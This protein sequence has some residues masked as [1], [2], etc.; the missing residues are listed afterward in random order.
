MSGW[1]MDVV[2]AAGV[3]SMSRVPMGLPASLPANNAFGFYKSRHQ[4]ALS[5]VSFS[6]FPGRNDRGEIWLT[7]DQ[8]DQFASTAIRRRSA[9]QAGAFDR[10][11][12]C[13]WK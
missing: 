2:I 12:S 8:L 13:R 5:G 1:Q 7:K 11:R 9:R 10:A 6:Q 4:E 3:E